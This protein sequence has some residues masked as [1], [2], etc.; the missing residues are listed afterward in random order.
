M[1]Y[2]YLAGELGVFMYDRL[3]QDGAFAMQPAG[4]MLTPARAARVARLGAAVYTKAVVDGTLAPASLTI[5]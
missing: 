2:Y 1:C 4:L 3:K 5:S